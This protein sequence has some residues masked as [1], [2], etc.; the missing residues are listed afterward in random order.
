MA[1][2]SPGAGKYQVFCLDPG[3]LVANRKDDAVARDREILVRVFEIVYSMYT[4][5]LEDGENLLA[6]EIGLK[7][8]N[9]LLKDAEDLDVDLTLGAVG[10][11]SLMAIE[12]RRWWKQ[13]FALEISV[14]EIMGSGTIMELG[15]VAA[16]R[17]K[18]K[19]GGG[20]GG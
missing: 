9:L 19:F 6:R 8:F 3:L 14:L 4:P 1:C 5:R 10:V 16:Q 18:V 11:D 7:V 12:L 15:K 13:A 2:C 17:L 20:K